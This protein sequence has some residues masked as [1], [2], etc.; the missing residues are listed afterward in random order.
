MIMAF[1]R[2]TACVISLATLTVVAAASLGWVRYRA[3]W[4]ISSSDSPKR[5]DDRTSEEAA[6]PEL[7]ESERER[8]WQIEHH[9][10]VL[11]K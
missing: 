11:S 2:S 4:I 10:N 8:L 3:P 1:S 7:A 5:G 6:I 9:G